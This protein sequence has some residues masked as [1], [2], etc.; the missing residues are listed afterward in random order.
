[1]GF[2]FLSLIYGLN[3]VL[4]GQTGRPGK[5]RIIIISASGMGNPVKS[6]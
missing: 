2:F 6:C 3:G 4:S 5:N 1:M